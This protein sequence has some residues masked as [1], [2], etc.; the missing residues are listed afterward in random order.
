[1]SEQSPNLEFD[2][3][4]AMRLDNESAGREVIPQ[5]AAA[6]LFDISETAVRAAVADGRVRVCF[7]VS[8][9]PFG[10]KPRAA[11]SAVRRAAAA[12]STGRPTT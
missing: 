8:V 11:T 1:M 10:G 4:E 7:Q 9:S 5:A 3:V 12:G 6:Q 2:R